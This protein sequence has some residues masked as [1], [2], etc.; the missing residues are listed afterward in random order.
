MNKLLYSEAGESRTFDLTAPATVIGRAPSCHL[1]LGDVS[2][3]REHARIVCRN[4][5][6]TI[7]DLGS[8][9]GTTVNGVAVVESP[10]HDGDTIVLG[11][12]ALTLQGPLD[13][14]VI[15]SEDKPLDPGS[16]TIV[17]SVEDLNS[18]LEPESTDTAAGPEGARGEDPGPEAATATREKLA[19]VA[20]A[21]RNLQILARV[22]RALITV[23][24]LHELLKKVMDLVFENI[25]VERGFLMLYDE[26]SQRLEPQVVRC[27]DHGTDLDNITISKT[28]A[29]RVFEDK[30]AIL[31]TDAQVDPRFKGGES[32]R[33]LGIRSAICA[34]LWDRDRVIGIIH[35][36]SSIKTTSFSED[37][38]ELLTALANYAAVAI[39]RARLNEKIRRE[40]LVRS[41]LERYH[42]PGVVNRIIDDSPGEGSERLRAKEAEVSV[43]FTDIV[44]FTTFSERKE[45]LHVSELLNEY[46]SVMT[47]EVFRREGTL[48]KY[49]GDSIMAVFGA[50]ISQED[51]AVRAIETALAMMEQLAELNSRRD[52]DDQF[53]IRAGINSGRVIAGDIGSPRRMEYTVLGDTVNVASRLES[54]V[55]RP[56]QVVV[57]EETYRMTRERF[58]W[59]HLGSVSLKGLSRT[60]DTYEPLAK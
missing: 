59:K 11:G 43:L 17:R 3:S 27:E 55:S 40:S 32:I 35:V 49:V 18:L 1:V 20:K 58:Q 41:R 26:E 13:H 34:P 7:R 46:L 37:D 53:R 29:D 2:I 50:P 54:S 24:P 30:V 21:N 10:L 36:D 42:S 14:K 19:R 25:P 45:P 16:G 12:F 38:L 9:N 47:D 39:E 56:G 51:H 6:L 57:G 48:D 8:K 31:T 28:I 5:T 44:G 60:Y 15:L 33:V 4:E 23:E 22:A 52:P